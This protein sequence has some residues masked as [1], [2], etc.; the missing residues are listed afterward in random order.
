MSYNDFADKIKDRLGIEIEP[1]PEWT[2]P[3]FFSIPHTTNNWKI[4]DDRY[5]RYYYRDFEERIRERLG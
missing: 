5:L 4:A 1:V 3:M 2:R